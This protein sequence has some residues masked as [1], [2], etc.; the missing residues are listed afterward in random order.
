MNELRKFGQL[1]EVGGLKRTEV[2]GGRALCEAMRS[3]YEGKTGMVKMVEDA[4]YD[5][6]VAGLLGNPMVLDRQTLCDR[7][8]CHY[9]VITAFDPNGSGYRAVVV[10]GKGYNPKISDYVGFE[11]VVGQTFAS[12]QEALNAGDVLAENIANQADCRV[13]GRIIFCDGEVKILDGKTG[14]YLPDT[15]DRE[16]F[17]E[18]CR[19]IGLGRDYLTS[20]TEK[21]N[22]YLSSTTYVL[23]SF[24]R[25]ARVQRQ[26][27]RQGN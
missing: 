5:N 16:T 18:Q 20:G 24:P 14:T 11:M 22:Y 10:I 8:D 27:Q 25:V 26:L 1:D 17:L 4:C 6:L 9:R 12:T 19:Q 15:S 3:R 7:A 13:S 2:E 21:T 23:P